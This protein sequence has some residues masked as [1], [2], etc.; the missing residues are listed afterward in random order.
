[1]VTG[2]P[3]L[4]LALGAALSFFYLLLNPPSAAFVAGGAL[5]GTR[6]VGEGFPKRLIDP[7]GR[8]HLL[9]AP[10]QRVETSDIEATI[11]Q[12][13]VFCEV[14]TLDISEVE[15]SRRSTGGVG[16]IMPRLEAGFFNKLTSVLLKANRQMISFDPNP[17][18]RR[19]A[20]VIPNFDDFFAQYKASYF[21]Q[22][23]DFLAS[24]PA[25]GVEVVF[26]NQRTTFHLEVTLKHATVVNE[27][28]C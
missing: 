24:D 14:K 6:I 8:E 19:I 18:T 1:M 17:S 5:D 27:S 20:F 9:Q 28:P 10:P 25:P 4:L 13:R 16:S 11:G 7:L 12:T 2:A 3:S 21:K 22:I 26:Y 23:D 15:A